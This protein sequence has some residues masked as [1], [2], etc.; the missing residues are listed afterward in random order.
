MHVTFLS[1]STHRNV[2]ISIWSSGSIL[3]NIF[4][5]DRSHIWKIMKNGKHLVYSFAAPTDAMR[6]RSHGRG[7]VRSRRTPVPCGEL[8]LPVA[9]LVWRG[10]SG[11]ENQSEGPYSSPFPFPCFAAIAAAPL[12][13]RHTATLLLPQRTLRRP[14]PAPPP[15]VSHF[16][17]RVRDLCFLRRG[18]ADDTFSVRRPPVTTASSVVAF[19]NEPVGQPESWAFRRRLPQCGFYVGL[20]LFYDG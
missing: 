14:L 15:K 17:Q 10:A 8:R 9:H 11:V 12:P 3:F 5:F 19:P 4:Y 20:D 7:R 2:P 18:E 1:P 6:S 13:V 16:L